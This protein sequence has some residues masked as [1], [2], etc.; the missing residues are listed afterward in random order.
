MKLVMPEPDRRLLVDDYG[1]AVGYV[2]AR[3][4]G[5]RRGRPS[6][7]PDCI[8]VTLKFCKG[9]GGPKDRSGRGSSYCGTC[10]AERKR[11]KDLSRRCERCHINYKKPGIGNRLC[12]TCEPTHRYAGQPYGHCEI[13]KELKQK[14]PGRGKRICV[15]CQDVAQELREAKKRARKILKRKPCEACGKPKGANRKSYCNVC[16]EKRAADKISCTACG[17]RPRRASGTQYCEICW[18]YAQRRKRNRARARSKARVSPRHKTYKPKTR[19]QQHRENENRRI[20]NRLKAQAAGRKFNTQLSLS[21]TGPLAKRAG[22]PTSLPAA[23]LAQLFV[24]RFPAALH[25]KAEQVPRDPEGSFLTFCNSI[26]IS[27]RSVRDWKSGARL[28]AQFDVIERVLIGFEVLWFDV[29]DPQRWPDL[30]PPDEWI[31]V[32]EQARLAFEGC[33][34]ADNAVAA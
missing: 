12:D 26:G 16:A 10:N 1:N 24:E 15:D 5:P 34:P 32:Y 30:Y 2:C 27:D 7:C 23:P 4:G 3:C 6:I 29:Y 31:K 22:I 28:T 8:V 20:D 18:A 17:E 19:E 11:Q 9:C 14:P 13:C 21:K 33:P 25:S